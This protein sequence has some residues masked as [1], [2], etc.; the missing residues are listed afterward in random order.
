MAA[1]YRRLSKVLRTNSQCWMAK[2]IQNSLSFTRFG[3]HVPV[4]LPERT[5]CIILCHL[6]SFIDAFGCNMQGWGRHCALHKEVRKTTSEGMTCE[7]QSMLRSKDA[8]WNPSDIQTL[9]HQT[10]LTQSQRPSLSIVEPWKPHYLE[11]A[12]QETA[13]QIWQLSKS[14]SDLPWHSAKASA[15]FLQF[16]APHCVSTGRIND[17]SKKNLVNDQLVDSMPSPWHRQNVWS[18]SPTICLTSRT[19]IDPLISEDFGYLICYTTSTQACSRS[20]RVIGVLTAVQTWRMPKIVRLCAGLD[21]WTQ[22]MQGV[23]MHAHL[24]EP[25]WNKS[26]T[27]LYSAGSLSAEKIAL[28]TSILILSRKNFSGNYAGKELS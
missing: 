17:A 18:F 21:A 7:K 16:E 4:T 22:A 1:K 8:Q 20:K 10:D 13:D 6:A 2:Q 27:S 19:C 24:H 9:V 5:C 12:A 15:K 11:C 26:Q 25:C 23:W 28:F 3:A 14:C